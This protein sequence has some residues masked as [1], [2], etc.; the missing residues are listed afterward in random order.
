MIT[1]IKTRNLRDPAGSCSPGFR[2]YLPRLSSNGDYV[3]PTRGASILKGYEHARKNQVSNLRRPA[4]ISRLQRDF[5]FSRKVSEIFSSRKLSEIRRIEKTVEGVIDSILLFDPGLFQT[6]EGLSLLKAMIRKIITVGIFNLP[7][8]IGFWK[9]FASYTFLDVTK[10]HTGAARVPPPDNFF[11]AIRNT[12][13]LSKMERDGV[14]K[15]DLTK[16]SHLCSSRQLPTGDKK[17]EIKSLWELK[18]VT[19]EVFKT[20]AV[21]LRDLYR[22]SRLIGRK[23][24]K[25]GPGP[26][27]NAHLSLATSGSLERKVHE[28]GRAQEIEDHVFPILRFVPSVTR[29]ITYPLGTLKDTANVPRWRTWCRDQPLLTKEELD[30]GDPHETLG[31]F[32]DVF[33]LGF[34]EAIGE[35]ILACALLEQERNRG[36]EVPLRVLTITEPGC[37]ARIVTTGPWWVYVVQQPLA[38]VSRGF[39]G[40]H[41]S[42]EA[43]MMRTDQAWQYLHMLESVRSSWKDDFEVLSSDL[44]SATD[45]IPHDV[46]VTALRGFF[47]GIGLTSPLIEANLDLLSRPRLCIAEKI[48]TIWTANRGVFMGEP[49]AKTVLTLVVTASEETAIRKFLN[50]GFKD[51]I[52]VPWR[53]FA[54]AGD[55]HIASGP[56]PYLEQIGKQLQLIGMILSPDK[57]ARSKIAVRFCEKGLDVR[58]IKNQWSVKTI[59]DGLDQYQASPFV[60]SI[61]VRLL[62][63]CSKSNESFNERNT[64]VGKAKSLGRTLRWLN[65]SVFPH[66]WIRMVRD[67]FFQRM[68]P[69][70]PSPQSGVYWHLLLP[71]HLGGVGLYVEGDYPDLAYRLPD[72]TKGL[73]KDYR[74]LVIDPDCDLLKKFAGF[75][76]NSSYRGY[77]LKEDDLT[78]VKESLLPELK[79]SPSFTMEEALKRE[80]LKDTLSSKSKISRLRGKGYLTSWELEDRV[81]KPF[82]FKQILSKEAKVSAFNTEA[83]KTRYSRL[84]DLVYRGQSSVTEDEIRYAVENPIRDERLYYLEQCEIFVNG[85]IKTGTV[86]E[87]LT[88]GLPNFSISWNM[89]GELGSAIGAS[90]LKEENAQ[91]GFSLGEYV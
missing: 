21:D 66:K 23:C 68:G 7:Q 33:R 65:P 49:L 34:D 77:S 43:G 2:C 24:R 9:Q 86:L 47:D 36:T 79:F 61:K 90:L 54:D 62:S 83:F 69:L 31:G 56:V 15:D 44:K 3:L 53:A 74:S 85:E 91:D 87:E 48:E 76:S 20:K 19:T 12:P 4:L 17:T 6:A 84:W 28:G 88:A 10:S 63:P 70:M 64:S 5:G 22:S 78:L 82:L 71:E 16:L 58:N 8:V 18:S 67:R 59:N 57:H 55:D 14:T 35:Q 25:A 39:L 27:R 42:C 37:K 81:T 50:K 72:L 38:H 40:S 30:L 46:A 29:E 73:I 32:F 41:R 75:T 89:F 26:I 60:D 11:F 45:T 1:T 52:Q 51:S 80:N 13:L